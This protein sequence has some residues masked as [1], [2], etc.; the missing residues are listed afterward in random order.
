LA[1]S[2][3]A[4]FGR[5]MW[6]RTSTGVRQDRSPPF[7]RVS[8]ARLALELVDL[9]DREVLGTPSF[10]LKL[11]YRWRTYA[12]EYATATTEFV[13]LVEAR[14]SGTVINAAFYGDMIAAFASPRAQVAAQH[15]ERALQQVA[16][17]TRSSPP[18]RVVDAKRA[19]LFPGLIDSHVHPTFGEWSPRADHS[20][21]IA[22]CLQG[23][24]TT[25][26][27]AGEVHV[28]AFRST[29]LA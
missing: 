8:D 1:E 13:P 27:S 19:A 9:E 12:D 11:P 21:W 18:G 2:G 25:M 26:I 6:K 3:M 16:P 4:S 15:L 10:K 17:P 23:G 28:P 5:E 20:H 24:T 7:T 14:P 29:W 22:H